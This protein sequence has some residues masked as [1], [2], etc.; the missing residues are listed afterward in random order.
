MGNYIESESRLYHIWEGI[1]SRCLNPKS[2]DFHNYG[3][4]GITV[5]PE[6]TNDYTKFRDW[7]LNNGYA[8]NL[9][10]DRIEND[11]NYEPNNCQWITNLENGRKRRNNK[12]NMEQAN[13]IRT[14]YNSGNYTQKELRLRFNISKGHISNLINN[15]RNYWGGNEK[16]DYCSMRNWD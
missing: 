3:G 4:R 6:W 9:T 10:I 13:E 1:K 11:G 16:R 2:K 12:L 8:D 5:C 7:A 14:L 15:K